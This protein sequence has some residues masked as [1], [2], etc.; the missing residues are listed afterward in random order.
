MQRER[1]LIPSFKETDVFVELQ[2]P[3]GTSLQAMDRI[4]AALIHDLRAVPGFATRP[5]KS[6]ARCCRMSW[7]T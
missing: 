4:S 3:P 7:R 1:S 5:R 2:A 6:A